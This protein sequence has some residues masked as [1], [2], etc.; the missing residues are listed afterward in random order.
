MKRFMVTSFIA[1]LILLFGTSCSFTNEGKNSDAYILAFETL[2]NQ[3]RQLNDS[4]QYFSLFIKDELTKKTIR[5]IKSYFESKYTGKDIYFYTLE[6][7]EKAGPYGKE[8]LANDGLFLKIVDVSKNGDE[9]VIY[10]EKLSTA[11]LGAIG[12]NMTL[13][14]EKDEWIVKIQKSRGNSKAEDFLVSILKY[15]TLI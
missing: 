12:M 6:E 1:V 5:S 2:L 8:T 14:L 15:K 3:E 10:G 7:I 13:L 11:G 9:I 4:S